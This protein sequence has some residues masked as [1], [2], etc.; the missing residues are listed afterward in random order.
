[1]RV[2]GKH[3]D[4]SFVDTR[5]LIDYKIPSYD[6]MVADMISLIANNRKLYSQYNVG[7]GYQN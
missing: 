7:M 2:P 6:Q 3:V 1:M 4:K 5:L